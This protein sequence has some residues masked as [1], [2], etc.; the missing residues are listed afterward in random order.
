MFFG[1]NHFIGPTRKFFSRGYFIGPTENFF[2]RPNM[3]SPTEKHFPVGPI[4]YIEFIL[5]Y[6]EAE[7]SSGGTGLTCSANESVYF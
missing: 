4:K 6:H 5:K 2:S 1:R 3:M 7:E